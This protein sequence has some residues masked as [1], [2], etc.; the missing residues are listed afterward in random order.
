MQL[1]SL[2]RS[3]YYAFVKTKRALRE[4]K[5]IKL[6]VVDCFVSREEDPAA[7]VSPL[8][9]LDEKSP[10]PLI[11]KDRTWLARPMVRVTTLFAART[12]TTVRLQSKIR[13]NIDRGYTPL[14]TTAVLLRV[15]PPSPPAPSVLDVK[16]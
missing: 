8:G 2:S 7:L 14:S 16:L 3:L 4:M 11:K 5:S 12:T 6:D 15:I 13:E 1:I 10:T 9:L